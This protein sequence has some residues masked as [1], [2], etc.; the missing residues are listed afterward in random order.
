MHVLF[1]E[2]VSPRYIYI[3]PKTNRV[4]LLVPVVGGQEIST[5]NTCRA[6]LALKEFFDGGALR[7]LNTYKD[8]LALDIQL[9]GED[10]HERRL[11]EER[12]TQIYAYIEAVQAMR[13]SYGDAFTALMSRP[14][15][16]YGIQLRPRTQDSQSSVV[17]PAFNIERRNDSNGVPLSPLYNAMHSTF[18]TTMIAVRDPRVSLTT[19]V[20]AALSSSSTVAD[21]QRILSEQ[22]MRL[23]GLPI[24]FTRQ[25]D[26]T[27]VNKEGINTLM[28]F[29]E[30][31]PPTQ[32]MYALLAMC[33]PDIWESIPTP[34]FYSMP[35]EML[36]GERTERLSILTQF[37][38]ANATIYCKAR[39]I[40]MQNFGAILDAS[41]YLSNELVH[42]V[43]TA[44]SDGYEVDEQI[45]T[46]C[47]KHAT[48]FGLSR[49][50]NENDITIIKQKFERTYRAVTA[51]KENP[52]MDDFMI[53]DF[54]ATGETAKFV[55][56]QGAICTD[57]AEVIDVFLPNQ[58]YFATIREDFAVHPAEI[59][60]KNES[61]AGG[62]ELEPEVLLTRI[63]E[64][65]FKKLPQ[66]VIDAC[67]AHPRFQLPHFLHDV[68][69]GKQKEAEALLTAVPANTQTILRTP[70][71]FTDY[72]D[73]TFN[74]TAYEYAYWAKDT[75]M[76][77][78]L[79]LL[80]DPDT[81]ALLLERIDDMERI[82]ATTGR[83]VGLVYKQ[84]NSEHRSAHFDFKPLKDAL[85]RVVDGYNNWEVT[86]NWNAMSAAWMEVGKAQRNIPAHVVQEYC[87]LDRTFYPTPAF[88]ETTLP[89]TLK[90]HNYYTGGSDSWF[91]LSTST[92][93][94]NFD[95][96]LIRCS[97]SGAFGLHAR[98]IQKASD[99]SLNL[100]AVSRLD[101]VR[102]VDLTLS[103]EHLNSPE[104][105]RSMSM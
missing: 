46:F 88:N 86:K 94:L 53:L 80:M 39:G 10:H 9:M 76:C 40:S 52:H 16:L 38:L 61:V 78:M 77:R 66:A 36:T 58:T 71:V 11:K 98:G 7:E 65:Q 5:D 83:S 74:C 26:G 12:L 14:S 54:D 73:R 31:T 23:F 60:H 15:N 91:P 29:A 85:Q 32:Y 18:F 22:C 72:S 55:T 70:G 25:T 104:N 3:N 13:H 44:L 79:E 28:A 96:G 42:V 35:E 67:H 47:N 101:E 50:L 100:V 93:R 27:V 89:R 4:H 81:K 99:V 2:P 51:T 17:N 56:H 68:A 24:D 45:G 105:S 8:A 20:L 59:P 87:R 103:R 57:F 48:E 97:L 1:T 82:D 19:A 95:F 34:P 69:K 41:P 102:T 49:A 62:I 6:T 64:E 92:V 43:A 63:N 21:I 30:D 75:H 37:Y 90:F 84:H 33:A